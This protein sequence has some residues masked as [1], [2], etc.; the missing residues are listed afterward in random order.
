MFAAVSSKLKVVVEVE[1]IMF[2]TVL[3][4]AGMGTKFALNV[5]LAEQVYWWHD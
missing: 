1:W 5:E 3:G 4:V 2:L